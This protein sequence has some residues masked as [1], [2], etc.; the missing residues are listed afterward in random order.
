[1]RHSSSVRWAKREYLLFGETFPFLYE[2]SPNTQ[3][4][5]ATPDVRPLRLGPWRV[6][7]PICYEDILPAHVRRMVN[8]GDPHVVVNL[9]D[10]VWL[11]VGQAPWIHFWLAVPRAVEHRRYLVRATN[12]GVSAIIDPVGRIVSHT[13]V[14]TRANLEG[15]VRM[16]SGTTVYGRFGDWPGW[17]SLGVV[18]F[19]SFRRTAL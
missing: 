2:L 7:T 11:G 17:L 6:S 19:M 12:S 16:M 4:F 1:M 10:D 5:T 3:K 13:S 9:T 8:D 14:G 15:T 18:A